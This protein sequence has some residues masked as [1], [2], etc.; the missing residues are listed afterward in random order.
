MWGKSTIQK[1]KKITFKEHISE[2]TEWSFQ[3]RTEH[4]PSLLLYM[5]L[6]LDEDKT[7]RNVEKESLRTH[8]SGP[9]QHPKA[10]AIF[11]GGLLTLLLYSCSRWYDSLISKYKSSGNL[12]ILSGIKLEQIKKVP[13]MQILKLWILCCGERSNTS[14][15]FLERSIKLE[16]KTMPVILHEH[17]PLLF[18]LS[19][20]KDVLKLL[21]EH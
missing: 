9:I 15:I 2:L 20:L 11:C 13:F 21:S 6:G 5:K 17:K 16:I 7:I 12:L 1:N 10:P 19:P 4:L 3:E 18:F 14:H 8:L